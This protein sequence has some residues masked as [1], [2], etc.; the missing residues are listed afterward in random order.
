MITLLVNLLVLVLVIGLIWWLLTQLPLPEPF[1]QAARIIFAVIA[2][3]M[4]IYLL[5]GLPG[6][7]GL[8][9]LR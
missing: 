7:A 9:R 6:E 8:I 3:I 5:V 1:G 2:V 4:V